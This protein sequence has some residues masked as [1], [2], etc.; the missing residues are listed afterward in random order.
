V[1]GNIRELPALLGDPRA[2]PNVPWVR[3]LTGASRD[4]VERTFGELE[5]QRGLFEE[6]RALHRAGGREFYA[7][8]RAPL[9]MY[10]L[11]RLRRPEHIVEAGVSSGLSSTFFLLGLAQNGHGRLHSIDLP[12]RQRGPKLTA[13]DSPVAVPPGRSSGWAVP[14]T[15][16]AGWDLRIGPSQKLLP[17][18]A[19]E[20]WP[21][22]LFL[23]DDLHTPTHLTFE[24]ETIRPRLR[25]GSIVLADNTEWTGQ[26]F[27]R[28]ATRLGVP[29]FR[30]GRS[31]LVGLTVPGR[32]PATTP[33]ASV[34]SRARRTGRA[35]R[36]P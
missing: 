23:H 8:I 14:P 6:I 20:G 34:R 21:V 30:K 24:L 9:E 35:R 5:S 3:H 33:A 32:S 13:A 7:Q 25:P 12:T 17:A 10:A 18:V 4:D 36:S 11:V 19:R 26:A 22:D 2:V 29:M 28:F 1:T 15:L 31:D 16:R 27:D